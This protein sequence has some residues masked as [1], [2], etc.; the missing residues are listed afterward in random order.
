MKDLCSKY[1]ILFIVKQ[2]ISL[3]AFNICTIYTDN[4]SSNTYLILNIFVVSVGNLK[5]AAYLRERLKA[6]PSWENEKCTEGF[7][8]FMFI[9]NWNTSNIT[10]DFLQ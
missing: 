7:C 8:I 6:D 9:L 3:S 1:L 5:N 4:I 10:Y 2:S